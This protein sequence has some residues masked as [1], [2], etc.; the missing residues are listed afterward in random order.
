MLPLFNRSDFLLKYMPAHEQGEKRFRKLSFETAF[1]L[2]GMAALSSRFSSDQSFLGVPA[3]ERGREFASQARSLYESSIQDSESFT[4]SLPYLQGCIL[5]S[6]Y[7]LTSGPCSFGWNLTGVCIRLAYDSGLDITDEDLIEDCRSNGDQWSSTEDWQRREELRRTW[8]SVWELDA[9]A[10]T[11]SGRPY[12]I[13]QTQMHV[14]LPAPDVNWFSKTPIAS[15]FIGSDPTTV[16]QCLQSSPNQ[17][18]RAWFLVANVLL[19]Q[20]NALWRRR[21]V[22]TRAKEQME[23][24]LSCF[25]LMLPQHFHLSSGSIVFDDDNFQKSNWIMLTN[26]LLQR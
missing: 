17:D 15:V 2:N 18:E 16:W 12:A 9:Y 26:I 1:L 22:P 23:Y 7:Q 21:V 14:L 11:L 19:L 13:D 10:S 8:W 24:A 3:S 6:F 25:G 20:A 4:S 5:L